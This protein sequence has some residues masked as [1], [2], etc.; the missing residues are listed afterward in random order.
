MIN[1]IAGNGDIGYYGDGGAAINASFESTP[2]AVWMDSQGRLFV[3]DSSDD[4]VRKIQS[5][6]SLTLS[7]TSP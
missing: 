2:K 3:V 4:R 6:G 1:T 7:L 5:S